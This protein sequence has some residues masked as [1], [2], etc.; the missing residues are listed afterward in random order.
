[1]NIGQ[2]CRHRVI[3]VPQSTSL[4]EVARVM[5]TEHVGA[6]IVTDG[7]HEQAPVV[8]IITDRDIVNAQLDQAKDLASLSAASAMTKN[9]LTL[10]RDESIDGA[11]AHMRARNVR[12][13]PVVCADAVPV[14]LVSVDDLIGQLSFD[15]SEI[16]S[17]VA[18][19][20]R[21]ES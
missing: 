10:T 13:A 12:R 1:M 18:R 15:L 5:S 20:P 14:G 9:V 6:V 3:K 21:C 8:G 17:I 4:S 16:A 11:I 7:S 2:L 19:Q